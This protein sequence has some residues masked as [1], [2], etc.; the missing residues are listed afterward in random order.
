MKDEIEVQREHA[1]RLADVLTQLIDTNRLMRSEYKNYREAMEFYMGSSRCKEALS[2]FKEQLEKEAI[3]ELLKD[4][5]GEDEEP[6]QEQSYKY[7]IYD[8]SQDF[9]PFED[10]DTYY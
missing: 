2:E 6:T 7:G 5:D 4:I 3:A 8:S 1:E 9:Y 10:K